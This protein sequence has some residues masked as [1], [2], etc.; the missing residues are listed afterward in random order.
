MSRVFELPV[1]AMR[2]C[3]NFVDH[4]SLIQMMIMSFWFGVMAARRICER[5][6]DLCLLVWRL[7]Q[8]REGEERRDTE[9][10]RN[11]DAGIP[12]DLSIQEEY[13]AMN[14]ELYW[15]HL[16]SYPDDWWDNRVTRKNPKALDFKHKGTHKALWLNNWQ[17]PKWA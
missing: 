11:W 13:L 3:G 2:V 4:M 7:V 8:M 1:N 17:T 10:L 16:V 14:P 6:Q 9:D 12:R 5:L 15:R